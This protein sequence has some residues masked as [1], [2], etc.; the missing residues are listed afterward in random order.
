MGAGKTSVLAIAKGVYQT[1]DQDDLTDSV[2]VIAKLDVLYRHDRKWFD[3]SGGERG[4]VTDLCGSKIHK[5]SLWSIDTLLHCYAALT[6]IQVTRHAVYL[7][8]GICIPH[9]GWGVHI[10]VIRFMDGGVPG[11]W[12]GIEA[13]YWVQ[14]RKLPRSVTS[15]VQFPSAVALAKL[16][17][18]NPYSVKFLA[19]KKD[20]IVKQTTDLLGHLYLPAI[21]TTTYSPPSTSPAQ[22]PRVSEDDEEDDEHPLPTPPVTPPTPSPKAPPKRKVP[23]P[24]P[25]APPKRKV[26]PKPKTPNATP[27]RTKPLTLRKRHLSKTVNT[28]PPPPRPKRQTPKRPVSK[29]KKP[30]GDDGDPMCSLKHVQT[31]PPRPRG[32]A[33]PSVFKFDKDRAHNIGRLLTRFPPEAVI[34]RIAKSQG[35]SSLSKEVCDVARFKAIKYLIELVKAATILMDNNRVKTVT[36]K[37]ISEAVPRVAATLINKTPFPQQLLM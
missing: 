28:P 23:T 34:R 17:T 5:I 12:P 33:P 6:W 10:D 1:T 32:K 19:D 14:N 26:S 36:R 37:H 20:A 25:K 35:I 18:T 15:N 13:L 11:A 21:N 30:E 31:F 27:K 3:G 22:S 9:E 8:C 24:S 16:I 2:K 4:H 7:P 29:R